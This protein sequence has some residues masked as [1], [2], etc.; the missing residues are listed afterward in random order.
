MVA[1]PEVFSKLV[2]L[3]HVP[4]CNI[5][6]QT[7]CVW[8][9]DCSSHE[10]NQRLIVLYGVGKAREE[11]RHSLRKTTKEIV[12]LYSKRNCIDVVSGDV[13][14]VKKKKDKEAK[15]TVAT[16]KKKTESKN[17]M[18]MSPTLILGFYVGLYT[19]LCFF[20]SSFFSGGGPLHVIAWFVIEWENIWSK[21][22]CVCS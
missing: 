8:Q 2:C 7:H 20:L 15:E 22:H 18:Y 3:K 16:G 21:L 14:K 19:F 13:G 12:K 4:E 6:R 1:Q 9:E 10:Y 17:V 5:V 11:A